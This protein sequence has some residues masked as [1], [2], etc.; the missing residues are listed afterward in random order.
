VAR[1]I[2]EADLAHALKTGSK[3]IIRFY[4]PKEYSWK[5]IRNHCADGRLGEFITEDTSGIVRTKSD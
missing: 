3:P 2:I 4:I 5:T 1:E